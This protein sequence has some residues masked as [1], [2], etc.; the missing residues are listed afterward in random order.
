LFAGAGGS[1]QGCGWIYRDTDG[2]S[3]IL[4][5]RRLANQEGQVRKITAIEGVP[6][7]GLDGLGSPAY[8]P[9][10]MSVLIPLGAEGLHLIR[11]IMAAHSGSLA[12]ARRA[13]RT[14]ASRVV[15]RGPA[16][17]RQPIPLTFRPGTGPVPGVATFDCIESA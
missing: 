6:A 9:E 4:I 17:A 2:F 13:N 14:G 16:G 15:R 12:A 11:L 7:M 8:G 5:E 3:R 1:L 10:A